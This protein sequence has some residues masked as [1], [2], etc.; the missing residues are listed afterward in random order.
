MKVS[1]NVK[2]DQEKLFSLIK[3]EK[4][5]LKNNLPDAQGS[6]GLNIYAIQFSE[7]EEENFSVKKK[8]VMPAYQI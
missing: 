7:A 5:W 4:N 3:R 1:V 2:K 8:N 6:K